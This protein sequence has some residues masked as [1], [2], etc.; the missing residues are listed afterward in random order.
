MLLK[1]SLCRCKTDTS[2]HDSD[3]AEKYNGDQRK[4]LLPDMCIA[5]PWCDVVTNMDYYQ[6]HTLSEYEQELRIHGFIVVTNSNMS[7]FSAN[8]TYDMQVSR[9]IPTVT[10]QTMD[11][12][13]DS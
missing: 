10:Q 13:S 5:G 6:D 3:I 12:L 9:L 1:L 8:V 2:V 11:F 4:N 7:N